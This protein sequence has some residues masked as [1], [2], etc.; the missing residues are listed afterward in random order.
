MEVTEVSNTAVDF[1]AATEAVTSEVI[2]GF[3]VDMVDS[4]A[5]IVAATV[6]VSRVVIR[7]SDRHG[8]GKIGHTN[9]EE[10]GVHWHWSTP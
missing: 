2:V 9:Y 7:V 5:V 10:L 3:M 4:A 6:V 8:I 1:M